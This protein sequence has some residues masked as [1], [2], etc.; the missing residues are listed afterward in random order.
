MN[1]AARSAD[2]ITERIERLSRLDGDVRSATPPLP[3][4][5]KI[6]L[7]SRCNYACRFCASHLRGN[8]KHDMPWSLYTRLA[9]ELRAAGVEQLGLFYIGESLLYERLAEA[10]RYAKHECGYPYVFLTTNGTLATAERVRELMLAGLDSLKFALNFADAAQLARGAGVTGSI[11]GELVQNVLDACRMRDEVHAQTGK[12]C[13]VS[14]SSLLYDALQPQR[15]EATLEKVKSRLDQHYWLPYYGRSQTWADGG[16]ATRQPEPLAVSRKELPCWP[17][18][19]E[20]HVTADGR[21][22]ACGLD[23]SPRFHA[24]DLKVTSLREAWQRRSSRRCAPRIF[25]AMQAPAPVINAWATRIAEPHPDRSSDYDRHHR[26][27]RQ[28][29]P[30]TAGIP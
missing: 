3:R 27:H 9:R 20:A 21:L 22:S 4:S 1:E 2:R 24:G 6:E 7:T 12:R 5:A 26:T 11:F 28:H 17:L 14:A 15:M 10:V 19:T 30:H 16:A 29:H 18:Y 13:T 25:A 23:H 8:A